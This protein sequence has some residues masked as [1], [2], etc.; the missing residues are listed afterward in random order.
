MTATDAG[1]PPGPPRDFEATYREGT[2]PWDIGRPQP[3]VQKLLDDGLVA[4][5][6]LD[7]GC[8]TGEN[9]LLI[10]ARGHAVMGLDGAPSAVEQARA[11]AAARGLGPPQVQFHV[12][13]A[14]QLGRLR[15]SFDTVLDCGLMHVFDRPT[16]RQYI[17]AV[18]EVTASG[19]DFFVLAF[20]DEEP[21]GRGPH[22]LTESEI[23]DAA[24]SIFAV[25]EI[26]PARLERVDGPPAQAWLARLT[27]I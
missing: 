23:R 1:G 24:R 21:A 2:P 16:R 14:L 19:A 6:V 15:K 13:D 26:E 4:G 22:R 10:A 25:M 18:A 8:G 27:R 20:S 17:Q 12:W 7:L 9:A 5:S 11:K 3:A